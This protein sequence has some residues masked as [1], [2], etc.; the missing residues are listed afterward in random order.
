MLF[1]RKSWVF[2]LALLVGSTFASLTVQAQT[3]GE[4]Y[5]GKTVNVYIGVGV[6]GEYDIQARLVARHI[7]KHIPGKP[8][9]VPQNMTG[10][11][12]LRMINYLYNVAPKYGLSIGMIANAF[13]AMQAAGIAGVQFDAAKM[14]WLGTIAPGVE[15]MAV[16]HTTGVKSIEE[17]RAREA[18][19]PYR[20]DPLHMD[21]IF[22]ESPA[23]LRAYTKAAL[24]RRRP[25]AWSC[26]DASETRHGDARCD[27]ARPRH[28]SRPRQG[29]PAGHGR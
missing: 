24:G 3:V 4:F 14:Q 16:W 27:Q 26:D 15:T 13:P 7:G 21:P 19:H 8:T 18:V 6:G 11:G 28:H 23:E 29:R 2:A 20:G 5:R 22:F 1:E 12:G 25:R 17:L 9:V 10:A